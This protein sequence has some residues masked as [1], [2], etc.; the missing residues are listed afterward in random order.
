MKYNLSK[1][2]KVCMILKSNLKNLKMDSRVLRECYSLIDIG[3][4]VTI[5]IFDNSVRKS[6][7]KFNAINIKIINQ[8]ETKIT[9][10]KPL[11][12]F[13]IYFNAY[14]KLVSENADIYYSHNISTLLLGYVASRKK[15]AKLVYDIHELWMESHYFKKFVKKIKKQFYRMLERYVIK[16]VD[17]VITVNESL[18]QHLSKLYNIKKPLVLHNF[19]N[20]YKHNDKSEIFRKILKIKYNYKIVLYQGVFSTGRGLENLIDSVHF[21]NDDIVVVLL[22]YGDLKTRLHEKICD[23]GLDNR[24]KILDAV[25]PDILIEYTASAH[26]GVSPIQNIS[27]SYYYSTPNKIWEYIIAGIPF[28]ASD[29]PEMRKLTIDEDMGEVFD[30]ENPKEIA[31]TIN[32]LLGNNDL[33]ERKKRNVLKLAKEKYNWEKEKEKMVKIFEKLQK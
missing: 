25:L 4:D 11:Y 3:Y 31:E 10:L 32:K 20:Y 30:P 14:R 23:L 6:F 18:S 7:E 16:K 24:V 27:L 5:V 2:K 13:I 33:Y 8:R 22:G 15:N 21:L 28:V 26:L 9:I 29:F 17:V 19:P 1:T 12:Q